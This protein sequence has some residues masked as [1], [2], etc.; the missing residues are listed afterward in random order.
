MAYGLERKALTEDEGRVQMG[1]A[2]ALVPP[3]R[4]APPTPEQT[5]M[6]PPLHGNEQQGRRARGMQ[7]QVSIEATA[8]TSEEDEVPVSTPFKHIN[9]KQIRITEAETEREE[10]DDDVIYD[11]GITTDNNNDQT[12][13]QQFTQQQ[14]TRSQQSTERRAEVA[15]P[16]I[17][18]EVN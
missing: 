3:D 8:A 12:E 15:E 16:Q 17:Y 2:N 11:V 5:R 6:Q 10:P 14:G 4:P 7:L 13:P 18:D 9:E 1:L